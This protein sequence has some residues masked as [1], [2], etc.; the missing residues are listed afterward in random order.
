[1]YIYTHIYVRIITKGEIINLKEGM[2]EIR[3]NERT[4]GAVTMM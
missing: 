3:R 1:M 4:E 2:G